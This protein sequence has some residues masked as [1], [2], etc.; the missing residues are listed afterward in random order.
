MRRLKLISVSL[1]LVVL[2]ATALTGLTFGFSCAN[3]SDYLL[4]T[5]FCF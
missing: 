3:F 5:G 1:V 2:I 4:T